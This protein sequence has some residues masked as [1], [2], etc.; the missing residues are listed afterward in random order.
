MISFTVLLDDDSDK[1]LRSGVRAEINVLYDIKEEVLRIPNGTYYHIGHG[2]YIFFI[3]NGEGHLLRREVR[4]GEGNF[5]YVEVLSGLSDGDRIVKND[6]A[7]YNS[8]KKI[9]LR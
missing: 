9:R 2:Q 4:L 5:D 7:E 3:D 8:R 1:R 6:L